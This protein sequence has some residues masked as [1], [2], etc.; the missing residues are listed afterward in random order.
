VLA[1]TDLAAANSS[2]SVAVARAAVVAECN[3]CGRHRRVSQRRVRRDTH[4]RRRSAAGSR[5]PNDAAGFTGG[6]KVVAGTLTLATNGTPATTVT[7]PAG[8]CLTG[9]DPR[10][11]GSHEVLGALDVVTCP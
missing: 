6:L 9:K 11:V 4:E 7:V 10:D 5:A 3:N 2:T 8:T 1:T